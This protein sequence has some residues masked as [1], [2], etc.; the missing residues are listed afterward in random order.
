MTTTDRMPIAAPPRRLPRAA[1]RLALFAACAFAAAASRAQPEE[2]VVTAPWVQ[3]ECIVFRQ[4]DESGAGDEHWPES[5]ALGYPAGLHF[6]RT[7]AEDAAWQSAEAAVAAALQPADVAPFTDVAAAATAPAT[8]DA[9]TPAGDALAPPEPPRPFVLLTEEQRT[10]LDAARRLAGSAQLRVLRYAAWRQPITPLGGA[11]RVL[12]TGGQPVADHFELEGSLAIERTRFLH[13]STRL[14]LND[15]AAASGAATPAGVELPPVPQPPPLPLPPQPEA[16]G[17][18]PGLIGDAAG[19]APP[20]DPAAAAMPA[21]DATGEATAAATL[22]PEPPPPLRAQR[23]VSLELARRVRLGE[24]HYFDHPLF[25][26]LIRIQPWDPAQPALPPPDGSTPAQ[27]G[28][29]PAA[30][31]PLPAP[32]ATSPPAAA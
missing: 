9:A 12:L 18:Q 4:L 22:A 2:E 14:W 15:F 19:M 23:T 17:L 6:L 26:V 16:S 32:A 13:V 11:D 27:P 25:G 24:L 30:P 28:M 5:P 10:L 7:P 21:E 31:A 8:G 29:A 20:A 1:A 3:V